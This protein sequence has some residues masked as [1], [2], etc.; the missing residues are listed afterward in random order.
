MSDQQP[1][2]ARHTAGEVV[3]RLGRATPHLVGERFVP[4]P[5]HD[6]SRQV[7]QP[8]EAV[9]RVLRLDGNGP[10][11]CVVLLQPP[12]R[13]NKRPGRAEPGHKVCDATVGLL[14]DL[15][16]GALVMR[17]RV[18]GI[19]V[20]V[21]IEV[22][23]G[24][25]GYHVAHHPDG[26]VGP[27]ARVAVHDAGAVSGHEGLA[28]C[29]HV[30]RHHKLHAVA[31]GRADQRVSDAGVA[32]GRIDDG[33]VTG[34]RSTPLA[35]FDHRQRRPVFDRASGIEPL[36]LGVNLQLRELPIEKPNPQKRRVANQ[37]RDTRNAHSACHR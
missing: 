28:L 26:A 29:T 22:L 23:V 15:H 2:G 5:R 18:R 4:D 16:R 30:A 7:L 35:V 21:G 17:A 36:G 1:F 20:L 25:R 19:G 27:F 3:G 12:R 10:D 31:L 34:Q 14:Q 37:P 8:F 24:T 9:E 11:G 13:A 33:L 6:C 32:G